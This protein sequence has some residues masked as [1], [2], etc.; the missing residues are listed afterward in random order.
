MTLPLEQRAA[1]DRALEPE[2]GER[3]EVLLRADAAGGEHRQARAVADA[4]EQVEVRARPS[5]RRGRSPCRGAARRPPRRSAR[6]ARPARQL[7][8]AA[9]AGDRHA[10]VA[11]VDGDD[12]PLAEG[13]RELGERAGV[14]NA[15][16]PTTTRA[17]PASSSACA[18]ATE[19]I[20]PDACTGVGD[21]C[22]GQR[23]DELRPDPAGA[24]A[25]EVD[26][27]QERR[28]RGGEARAELDRIARAGDDLVEL[29]AGAAAPPR[30]R[31]R[32]PPGSAGSRRASVSHCAA[33]LTC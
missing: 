20:P 18:S 6:R 11:H 1:D 10:A 29:A 32:R 27:V 16:V 31:R 33:M 5:S 13:A 4:L 8:H 17:A 15:A 2:R 3:V 9:P 22:R 12:E 26:D 7:R 14:A 30:P 23:A 24:R 28:A 19:R 21:G 25:V